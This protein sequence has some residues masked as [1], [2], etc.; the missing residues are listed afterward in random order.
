MAFS[1]DDAYL[2][3]L[4]RIAAGD[5]GT[6]MVHRA[7]AGRTYQIQRGTGDT[8]APYAY[9][10]A[11]VR[12]GE[13][14][15]IVHNTSLTLDPPQVSGSASLVLAGAGRTGNTAFTP[16][17]G[18]TEEQD[19]GS[20]VGAG[21]RATL[22]SKTSPS[23]PENPGTFGVTSSTWGATGTV[24]ITG[25]AAPADP[26][27][28]LL[29]L[30]PAHLWLFDRP[31]YDGNTIMWKEAA[32]TNA[33]T[34]NGDNVGAVECLVTGDTLTAVSGREGTYNSSGSTTFAFEFPFTNS[35][36]V[37]VSS[38]V[39]PELVACVVKPDSTSSAHLTGDMTFGGATTRS[40][41]GMTSFGVAQ[42]SFVER[43]YAAWDVS[44]SS[45]GVQVDNGNFTFY[46]YSAPPSVD[47]LTVQ[48]GTWVA[49]AIWT[50]QPDIEEV[51][52]LFSL[53]GGG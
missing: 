35:V 39:T 26:V 6:L 25:R 9:A 33:V 10:V 1:W 24:G 45:R 20:S 53:L 50:T 37:T 14:V 27:A 43:Q 34:A 11:V 52:Y 15:D 47:D 16:P 4:Q 38:T 21:V 7:S 46:S 2:K 8:A 29:A 32:K 30:S 49:L 42:T 18:Y 36:S 31:T 48:Q 5:T 28:S 41:A 23:N 13:I 19:V 44:E 17:S 3:Y 12:D 51:D 40:L 22:I